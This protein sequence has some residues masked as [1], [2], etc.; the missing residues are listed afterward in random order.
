MDSDAPFNS[1]EYLKQCKFM[2]A[3]VSIPALGLGI[4][5]GWAN[6]YDVKIICLAKEGTNP[7]TSLSVVS[8]DIIKYTDEEDMIKKLEQVLLEN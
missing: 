3:E 2:I 8:K 6:L 5:I 4:E 7:S 1:K